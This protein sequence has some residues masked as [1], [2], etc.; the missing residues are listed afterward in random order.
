MLFVV[1][2]FVLFYTVY[3]IYSGINFVVVVFY[4]QKD[5]KF[6]SIHSFVFYSSSVY[7]YESVLS[8]LLLLL[9]C[10][11]ACVNLQ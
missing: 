4:V 1:Y 6:V 5:I 3:I 8:S 9:L 2:L 7:M 11:C 10:V